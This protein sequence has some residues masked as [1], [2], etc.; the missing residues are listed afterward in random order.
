MPYGTNVGANQNSQTFTS[1]GLGTDTPPQTQFA[2]SPQQALAGKQGQY[3]FSP[4]GGGMNGPSQ[5]ALD[6]QTLASI[7]VNAQMSRFNQLLPLLTGQLGRLNN[8][9][10]TAGGTNSAA[11]PISTGP[12]L[13]PQQIQQ[14]V[15]TSRAANDQAV[16][17]QMA[18]SNSSLAGRGFGSN[19]PL[20]MALNQGMQNN[21]LA[22]NT[23]NETA[24]RLNAAQQNAAQQL[25]TQQ[26]LSNQW[27]TGNQLDIQR[28]APVF[29]QQNAL[30]AALGG[31]MA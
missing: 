7:P 22:T 31:L 10:A 27:A 20:Q 28:R 17:G 9:F 5:S 21:A 23:A 15:N 13:N 11:P 18:Q 24:T 26:A 6:Q 16:A 2:W 1:G 4:A 25:N 8:G 14:Q 19:S 12:T 29:A 30:I 3:S